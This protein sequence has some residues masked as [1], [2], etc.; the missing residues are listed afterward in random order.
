MASPGDLF[1]AG[2]KNPLARLEALEPPSQVMLVSSSS[3]KTLKIRQWWPKGTRQE[4]LPKKGPV[5]LLI[6]GLSSRS[7]WMSPLAENLMRNQPGAL[8]YGLDLPYVGE[9][10]YGEGHIRSRK[11]MVREVKEAIEY[12][13]EKH[14][15]RVYVIGTSLGG[16]LAS[17]VAADPPRALAGVG[18][19]SPAF[20]SHPDLKKDILRGIFESLTSRNPGL[21]RQKMAKRGKTH[22]DH[23]QAQMEEYLDKNP[24]SP[25]QREVRNAKE[26]QQDK[27]V[28]LSKL[29]YPKISRLMFDLKYFKAKRIKLPV[30]AFVTESDHMIDPRGTLKVLDKIPAENKS[31][32][33]FELAEHDLVVDPKLPVVAGQLN[34]WLTSLRLKHE[35]N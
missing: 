8:M 26:Y 35:K 19:I 29:S 24:L 4:D 6:H 5:V 16:L 1:F 17:H 34:R 20:T 21:M 15:G 2:R 11:E 28:T 7:R 22:K 13:A 10:P 30:C 12:L 27:V 18:L 33:V 25:L 23:L 31:V 14:E 32:R 3:R 9:H